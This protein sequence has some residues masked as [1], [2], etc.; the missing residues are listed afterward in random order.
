M[1]SFTYLSV[2]LSLFLITAISIY[3]LLPNVNLSLPPGPTG[4]LISGVAHIL[5]RVEPWKTYLA[6]SRD[7]GESVISFRVYNRRI[8][9]LN[10]LH[11][12]RTLFENRSDVYSDRPVNWMFNTILDRGKSIFNISSLDERHKQYRKHITNGLGVRATRDYWPILEEEVGHLVDGLKQD[13]KSYEK[14][15]QRNAAGVIMKV[16]FGYTVTEDD[17]FIKV[18][19][20]N[21]KISS[22]ALQPGRWLVDYIPTLRFIPAWFPGATWKRQGHEWRSRLR[23]LSDIPHQWVKDQI[24]TGIYTESFTSRLLYPGISDEEEDIVK[25]CAGGLYAGAGDTACHFTVSALL[26]FMHL[27]ALFPSVQHTA[28]VEIDRFPLEP[29]NLGK[30][31]YLQAVL[32]EVLRFA[33]VGNIALPH[34]VIKDDEYKGYRIPKDATVIPN[35]WAVLH[36]ED[37]YPDPFQFNPDRFSSVNQENDINPDPK[38]FAFGFGKR[39]C[40]GVHFAETT[41]LLAMAHILAHFDIKLPTGGKMDSTRIEFTTGITSTIKPFDID[42]QPRV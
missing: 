30:M 32:K 5:P 9:I 26:S 22:F 7:F 23:Y 35:V 34:R 24:A 4:T 37:I 29:S 20:E 11:S 6:W 14:H 1:D 16:A 41:M 10:D 27:M 12:I 36:D 8:I 2:P 31:L 21:G 40:P 28:Q 3:F 42:I 18:A 15:I 33:P 13:A 38:Q 19:H 39:A 17:A 25:W